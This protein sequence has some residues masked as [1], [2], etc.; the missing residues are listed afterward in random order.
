MLAFG[1]G[2][3]VCL[4]EQLATNRLFMFMV[5]LVQK[6]TFCSPDGS[7]LVSCQ[8]RDYKYATI[9]SPLRYKMVVRSR[10][11]DALSKEER[12]KRLEE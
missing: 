12:H 7:D 9:L 6:F 8:P 3:R 5:S 11:C 10:A 1:A 4:G 2:P